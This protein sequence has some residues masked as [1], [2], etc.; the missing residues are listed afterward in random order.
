MDSE[1]DDAIYDDEHEDSYNESGSEQGDESDFDI[2]CDEPS[3]AKRPH[4]NDDFH[5]ECLT[6]EALVS[7]MNDIIDEVNNVFQVRFLGFGKYVRLHIFLNA[8]INNENFASL[9]QI[10]WLKI[11]KFAL[12]GTSAPYNN[13]YKS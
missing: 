13:M 7:Y 3:T 9:V 12:A 4:I 11:L 2:D 5:Y 6:P 10:F 1:D 8:N